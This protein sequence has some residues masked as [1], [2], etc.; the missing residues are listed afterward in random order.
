ML[1]DIRRAMSRELVM[2]LRVC[3]NLGSAD[4]AEAEQLIA[5]LGAIKRHVEDR[6]ASLGYSERCREAIAVCGGECCRWHFPKTINRIDFFLAVFG[7]TDTE[8]EAVVKQ[9]QPTDDQAYHCPLLCEDGCI[10]SFANRPV[11]CTS[12]FPCM[13]GSDYWQYKESFRKEI[14][15]FRAALDRLIDRCAVR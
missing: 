13:A 9:V 10:F 4:A 11:V 1:A 14:D 3:E 6:A 5:Q 8:K 15:N 2:A 7:M 12:A